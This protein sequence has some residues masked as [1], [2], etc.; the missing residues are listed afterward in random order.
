MKPLKIAERQF[1]NLSIPH[2]QDMDYNGANA[3]DANL[4]VYALNGCAQGEGEEGERMGDVIDMVSVGVN[5]QIAFQTQV[6]VPDYYPPTVR[7]ILYIDKQNDST[8]RDANSGLLQYDV[9]ASLRLFAFPN[10]KYKERFHILDDRQI[11]LKD[12]RHEYAYDLGTG[13]GHDVRIRAD[14][15]S[16][17]PVKYT[18]N[19]PKSVQ[20][21]Y[22]NAL[23]SN[24]YSG[25]AIIKN[26]LYLGM[27][28]CRVPTSSDL[29]LWGVTRVTFRDA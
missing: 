6:I 22:F 7:L 9:D 27:V 21:V 11:V 14:Q 3:Y 4:F 17:Y 2:N 23:S 8:D 19:V 5:V 20:R 10:W 18:V 15:Q 29:Y 13:G 16:V 26:A 12:Y 24:L 28:S 1:V 25:V